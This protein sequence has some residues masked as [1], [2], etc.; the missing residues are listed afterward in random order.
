MKI[1]ITENQLKFLIE[2]VEPLY[3]KFADSLKKSGWS[4]ELVRASVNNVKEDISNDL[5]SKKSKYEG[6]LV[7]WLI[8]YIEERGDT[9][10]YWDLIDLVKE[11]DKSQNKNLQNKLNFSI[12]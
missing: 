11:F 7:K 4:D 9:E 2:G 5:G 1:K 8:D 10:I 12:N 3:Q 6:W